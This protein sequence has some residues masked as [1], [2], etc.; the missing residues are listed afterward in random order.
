MLASRSSRLLPSV[1]RAW[2]TPVAGCQRS[3][4]AWLHTDAGDDGTLYPFRDSIA[5]SDWRYSDRLPRPKVIRVD[6]V[7]GEYLPHDRSV[8]LYKREIDWAERVLG[9]EFRDLFNVVRKHALAH[10]A[11]HLGRDADDLS[12]SEEGLSWHSSGSIAGT[13]ARIVSSNGSG[14]TMGYSLVGTLS[15]AA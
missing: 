1:G 10:A 7:L 6:G 11:A 15:G 4:R 9:L 2:A 13:S 14:E 3:G 12:F 8:V 5:P